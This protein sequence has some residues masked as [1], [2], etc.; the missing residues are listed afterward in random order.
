MCTMQY[1]MKIP[2]PKSGIVMLRIGKC[3]NRLFR[4]KSDA[5]RALGFE[6]TWVQ[7]FDM[8]FNRLDEL[9]RKKK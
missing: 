8:T 2:S 5:E 9:E 6:I 7:F 3:W 1:V 4:R